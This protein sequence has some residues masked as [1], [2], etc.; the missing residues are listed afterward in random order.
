[1][2]VKEYRSLY[3]SALILLIVFTIGVIGF[4]SIEG[5][6]WVEAVYMTVITMS[7]VGFE[8]IQD[9]SETGMIFTGGLIISSFGF[10]A[11]LFTAAT[12][13][14][15]DGDYK[16]YLKNLYIQK[17]VQKLDNHVIV[18]GFGRNG[19]QAI[20]D[21]IAHDEKVVLI[22]KSDDVMNEDINER[23]MKEQKIIFIQGDAAHEESLKK[24]NPE[25]AKALVST[26]PNDAENL[27]I[28]LTARDL[29]PRLN[30]ISRASEDNSYAK[31]RRAGASHVIM[32]D[33]VGGTRM[34]K[35]V[36]QPDLIEF[37]EMIM[38]SEGV[39]V[40]LEEISCDEIAPFYTSRTIAKLNIRKKT[41]ANLIGI[42]LPDGQYVFNPSPGIRLKSGMKLFVIGTLKQV[43][44]LK[45]MLQ[46][47]DENF[48]S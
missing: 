38:I 29:N 10:F 8:E 26:L 35:L 18:C 42:K 19:R 6:T 31:L 32:P 45:K 23:F 36:S 28:I 24:A 1:M 25:N 44:E 34:A 5:F 11:Y 33:K 41:G 30:I 12:R 22:E 9:L 3:I 4:R 16:K 2:S 21:L 15:V 37:V 17:K 48:F 39:D 40:N 13:L 43:K 46:N 27:L 14:L 47:R 20:I 7:T